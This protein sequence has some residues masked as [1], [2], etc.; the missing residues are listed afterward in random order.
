MMWRALQT[1]K[2]RNLMAAMWTRYGIT[3]YY[4]V[5]CDHKFHVTCTGST[6]VIIMTVGITTR[7][8]RGITQCY[9]ISF[10]LM[11]SFLYAK[12]PLYL[13]QTLAQMLL[14]Q[15]LWNKQYAMVSL[16]SQNCTTSILAL[17]WVEMV[18]K[19]FLECQ[20]LSHINVDCLCKNCP[21]VTQMS[22]TDVCSDNDI[23][24]KQFPLSNYILA[25]VLLTY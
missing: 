6:A 9:T 20:R 16:K 12:I 4:C 3:Q 10:T 8:L 21:S 11:T 2:N 23:F 25:V 15:M 13:W 5:Y 7:F 17:I 1:C 22:A 24:S 14:F 18:L 19:F